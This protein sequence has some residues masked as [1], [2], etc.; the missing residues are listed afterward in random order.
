MLIYD[1]FQ[2]FENAR[3]AIEDCDAAIWCATGFSDAPGTSVFDK[4]KKLFGIAFAPKQSIDSIGVPA[5]AR[6]FLKSNDMKTDKED[7]TG[8]PLP[9]V[10]MLSSAGVTR[11]SWDD[12]KK[13]LFPGAADIPIV[14]LNPFGILDIKKDSEEKLRETGKKIPT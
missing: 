12:E 7:E 13:T 4:I 3:L 10:V 1:R 8:N 2:K 6:A 9:K 5:L 11:P 14:R